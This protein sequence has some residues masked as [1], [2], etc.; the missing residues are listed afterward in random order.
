MELRS[1]KQML[2]QNQG[3]M[4]IEPRT[5]LQ[6]PAPQSIQC[7]YPTTPG[8]HQK[9]RW[10]VD[11]GWMPGA[12][13][14]TLSLPLL[15]LTQR[16]NKMENNSQGEI[17]QLTKGKEKVFARKSKQENQIIISSRSHQKALP[18]H[19]PRSRA[20]ARVGV[21]PKGKRCK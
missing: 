8:R 3:P 14:A 17:R 4:L 13:R 21:A 2:I 1:P 11:L 6:A 12:H 20:S 5:L 10:W 7:P 16:E 9:H 18:D 15:S 19:F